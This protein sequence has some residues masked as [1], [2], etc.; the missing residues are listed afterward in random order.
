[1]W[2]LLKEFL[3]FTRREGKWWLIPLLV[4]LVLLGAI[5]IFT[6]NSGFAW[7]MYHSR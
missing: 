7:A 4:V 1:M 5:V 2:S 6:S 3:K